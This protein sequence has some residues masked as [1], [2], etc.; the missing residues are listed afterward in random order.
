M[1]TLTLDRIDNDGDYEPGNC[2]WATRTEQNLN[3][4]LNKNNRS[5]F[6]GVSRHK[7]SWVSYISK[8][9]I[10]LYLGSF[11]TSRE[12]AKAYDIAALRLHGEYAKL[13]FKENNL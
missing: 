4:R 13:N 8:G 10:K 3:R 12:A 11:R 1:P 2:R 5:G 7:N 9:D 6:R